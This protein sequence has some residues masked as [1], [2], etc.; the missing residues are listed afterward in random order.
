[1]LRAT[2]IG[3]VSVVALGVSLAAPAQAHMN[4]GGSSM[5]GGSG[6]NGGNT[7][8]AHSSGTGP[9]FVSHD[10]SQMHMDRDH[11]DHDHMDRDHMDHDHDRH[12]FRFFP[13]FAYG[14]DT[15]AD[16][17]DPTYCWEVIKVRTHLGLR[18]RRVWVCDQTGAIY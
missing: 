18:Y 6:G 2:T 10:M 13:T 17:Y 8:A 9:S 1:M 15:Y 5:H 14:I 7:M 4:G 16:N 12:H 11:M 3:I